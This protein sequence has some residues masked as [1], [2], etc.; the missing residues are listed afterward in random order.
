MRW[1]T[2]ACWTIG[3]LSWPKHLYRRKTSILRCDRSAGSPELGQPTP[4][5]FRIR[6]ASGSCALTSRIRSAWVA[7]PYAFRAT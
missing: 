1:N 7:I 6:F 3:R 4:K 2:S 5:L